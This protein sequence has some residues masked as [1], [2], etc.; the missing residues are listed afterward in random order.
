MT[1]LHSIINI[2]VDYHPVIQPIIVQP[3]V[4]SKLQQINKLIKDVRELPSARTK[5]YY[6]LSG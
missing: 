5:Y 3:V 2:N 6:I 1:I 4:K